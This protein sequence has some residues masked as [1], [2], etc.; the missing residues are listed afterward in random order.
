MPLKVK[1]CLESI[2]TELF[3]G[4]GAN[5]HTPEFM[6][7]KINGQ[8]GFAKPGAWL[9]NSD[10]IYM[11][12]ILK[13]PIGYV[14]VINTNSENWGDKLGAQEYPRDGGLVFFTPDYPEKWV[15]YNSGNHFQPL[16]K[17]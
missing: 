7:D 6:K 14:T 16:I 9:D 17:K 10:V 13:R 12:F 1:L 2:T 15:I 4:D 3:T 11:C 8:Y 5:I